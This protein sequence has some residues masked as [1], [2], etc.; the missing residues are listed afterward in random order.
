MKAQI[1][2]ITIGDDRDIYIVTKGGNQISIADGE[3]LFELWSDQNKLTHVEREPES[4][5]VE[6]VHRQYDK[7]DD[8][9]REFAM[10]HDYLWFWDRDET[11]NLYGDPAEFWEWSNR[12]N[13]AD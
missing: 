5:D 11:L 1:F 6:S 7:S 3:H 2:E 4:D 9:L 10:Q 13:P 8:M 12:I